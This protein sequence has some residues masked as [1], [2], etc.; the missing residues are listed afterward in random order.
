MGRLRALIHAQQTHATRN[1]TAQQP[2]LHVAP[3]RECNTQQP[4]AED[5]MA[6]ALAYLKEH[7]EAK[8]VCFLD[9][10]AEPAHIVLTIALREPWGALELLV[11]RNKLDPFA[12]MELSLRNPCT[13]LQVAQ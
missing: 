4:M 11:A 13:A 9:A 2:L 12:L 6:R 7:P 5:R 1:A 10:K 3:P 8:R